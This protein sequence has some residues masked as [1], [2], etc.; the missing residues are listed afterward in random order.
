MKPG[1]NGAGTTGAFGM[2]SG[3]KYLILDGSGRCC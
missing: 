2:M 3:S 1:L